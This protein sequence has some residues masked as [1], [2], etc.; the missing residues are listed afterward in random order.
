MLVRAVRRMDV[1][2]L[3]DRRGVAEDGPR[4]QAGSGSTVPSYQRVLAIVL[5]E[6]GRREARRDALATG[7]DELWAY[8]GVDYGTLVQRLAETRRHR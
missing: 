2:D 4:S 6:R 7:A 1:E 5:D 3:F 8:K